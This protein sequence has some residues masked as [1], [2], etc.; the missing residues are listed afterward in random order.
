MNQIRIVYPIFL[1]FMD[2]DVA[3]ICMFLVNLIMFITIAIEFYI[4]IPFSRRST[5]RLYLT[6]WSFGLV[7]VV[8]QPILILEYI[9]EEEM[10]CITLL[11]SPFILKIALIYYNKIWNDIM[12]NMLNFSNSTSKLNKGGIGSEGN[13]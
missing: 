9:N 4:T 7:F 8:L 12:F 3:K 6:V 1:F 10:T 13:N 11:L 5:S 2:A